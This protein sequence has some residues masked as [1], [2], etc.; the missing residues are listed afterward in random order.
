MSKIDFSYIGNELEVFADA[1][2][3]RSYWGS[4]V[5]PYLGERV[6]EVGAG[7]GSVTKSLCHGGVKRWVAVEPDPALAARLT[8]VASRYS[9]VEPKTG[10]VGDLDA[11]D[12]FDSALYIDVLEHLEDDAA[13]LDRVSKHVVSGGHIIALGPAHP[14]LYTPFDAAIGHHRRYNEKS[15]KQLKPEGFSLVSIAY[16]DS[17]GMMASLGNKFILKSAQPTKNQI[18]MWDQWMV[19]VSRYTDPLLG[20]N[21]GKSILAIWKKS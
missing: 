18:A 15:L 20:F 7:L 16:L 8:A 19:P 3:W 12:C 4:K 6:L 9:A 11:K 5:R 14:F 1:N 2:N 21:C 10:T 13:E 17:I